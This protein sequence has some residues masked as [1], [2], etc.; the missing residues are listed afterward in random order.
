MS[1]ENCKIDEYKELYTFLATVRHKKELT[2]ERCKELEALIDGILIKTIEC[3]SVQEVREKKHHVTTE[4]ILCCIL[5]E[6]TEINN[7]LKKKEE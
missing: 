4:Y 2:E 5:E 1:E 6:L 7:K 3:K